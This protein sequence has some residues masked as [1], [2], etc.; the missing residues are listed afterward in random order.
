M[1]AIY[2]IKPILAILVSLVAVLLIGLTGQKRA[3]LREFWTILA[4]VLKFLI[5]MSMVPTIMAGKEIALT[6]FSVAP[7]LDIAFKVDALGISFAVTASFLWIITS[8][9][10]IGYVRK[11]GEENLTRYFM[12]FAVAMS[13]AM[14]AAFSGNLFTLF[15]F[16]EIITFSTFPLISHKGTDAAKSGARRYLFYLV[17]TSVAFLLFAIFLTYGAAGSLDFVPGGILSGTASRGLL[18][19]IFILFIA[20]IAKAGMMPFHPWLPAAMVAPTPVSALL[21]A[22][23]VVKV[24]VFTVLRVVLYVFGVDLLKEIGV[25]TFFVYFAC[26]TI[27]LASLIALK[28]DNLKRRLAYSTISQLSYII[29]GVA[30]LSPSGITGSIMHIA[31]HA[32]GKITLFFCAGAIY[33]AHHK[34]KVSELDGIGKVMPFTMAAFAI[35]SISMIGIPPAAGIISKWYLM[36]GA[37]EADLLPVIAV[38]FCSTILNACYF[39]PIIYAAFFKSG[40]H[41]LSGPGLAV[42][43]REAPLMMVLPI[44]V[45]ATGTIA[46]FFG[47]GFFLDLAKMVVAKVI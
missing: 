46:L 2:S 13:A 4:A 28:Q 35:G 20:G 3:N 33:A 44:M 18:V 39:L 12:C 10:S 9:Y 29:L 36:F 15:I 5:V 42:K 34:T 45:T 25:G 31:I 14:G 22:V 19:A 43:I 7:G 47:P 27:L 41:Q 11:C 30:L 21:H 24:G 6:L 16:Y 26:F 38:L 40:D 37:I 17:G 23:A 8:F 32:F 1:D